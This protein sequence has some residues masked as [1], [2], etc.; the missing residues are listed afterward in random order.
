MLTMAPVETVRQV[1]AAN[2]RFYEAFE[3]LDIRRM[4]SVWRQDDDVQCI[5]PGWPRLIGWQA[6]RDSWIRIFNNTR[7]MAFRISDAKIT[8]Q[9][10][11]AWVVCVERITMVVDEEPQETRVL[12]T[13]IFR[14][15]DDQDQEN[16]WLMVLHHGSPVLPRLA[17]MPDT[18][19]DAVDR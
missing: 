7:S 16:A 4:A 10:L 6:V 13:N 17:D 15:R 1:F 14:R 9:G 2:Q 18:D 8:V 12:A 3:S 19:D 5:H 11:V